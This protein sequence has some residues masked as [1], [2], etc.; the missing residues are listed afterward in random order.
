MKYKFPEG[1]K[2]ENNSIEKFSRK[3]NEGLLPFNHD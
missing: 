1:T 3:I 2:N